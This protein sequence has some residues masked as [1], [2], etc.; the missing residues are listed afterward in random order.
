M[1][2]GWKFPDPLLTR[3]RDD[4][5][6]AHVGLLTGEIFYPDLTARRT[7][8]VHERIKLIT[9]VRETSQGNAHQPSEDPS[10]V[11]SAGDCTI[12]FRTLST[13]GGALRTWQIPEPTLE[14]ETVGR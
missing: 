11:P 8:P 7:P 9:V 12:S 6:L 3:N 1:D 10:F 2:N 4:N 13:V 14:P 5:H